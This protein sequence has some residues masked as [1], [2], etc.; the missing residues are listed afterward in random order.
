MKLIIL[1]A[2]DAFELDGYNKLLIKHPV[3]NKRIIEL[4]K[5]YFNVEKIEIVVGYKAIEIMNL[6]PELSYKYNKNWQTTSSGYSLS[7]ALSD[8]PCYI[9][10]SD[11][12]LDKETVDLMSEHDNCALIKCTENRRPSSLNSRVSSD[13]EIESIYRG[14][15]RNNDPEL[16]GVFKVSD[17]S[18]L[19]EWRKRC[20]L[21]PQGYA[22]ENLP[23]GEICNIISVEATNKTFE[24]N[25]PEDYI[26]FLRK[27]K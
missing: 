2:G 7:L 11:F 22:G 12:I 26:Q 21:N 15:S 10:P 17:K 24:I 9:V 1:D 16:T 6:Y 25:T 23:L 5:E 14:Q 8:E 20:V 18:L 4:Y 19:L 3:K 13:G 27:V